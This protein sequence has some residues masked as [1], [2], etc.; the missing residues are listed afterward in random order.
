MDLTFRTLMDCAH[1]RWS[2]GIGDPGPTGWLTVVVYL[3]AAGMGFAVVARAGFP[4][5]TARRERGLWL[6]IATAMLAL[7]LNKQLDLQSFLTAVGRCVAQQQGWY[8]AR[9]LVQRE[10]VLG[11]LAAMLVLAGLAA[12]LYRGTMRRNGLAVAG[13]VFVMGFVLIRAVGFHHVDA[14]LNTRLLSVRMNV[15]LEL[16]GPVLIMI[17]GMLLLGRR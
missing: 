4:A 17:G 11:L 5:A 2:P 13:T 10:F 3:L 7:A 6:L 14:M 1:A 9:R 16:T 12:L 15:S 8:G